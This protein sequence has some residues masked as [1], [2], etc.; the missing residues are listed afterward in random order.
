[1]FATKKLYQLLDLQAYN[2]EKAKAL[3]LLYHGVNQKIFLKKWDRLVQQFQAINAKIYIYLLHNRHNIIAQN[4][5]TK[6]TPEQ[7]LDYF[8]NFYF[9]CTTRNKTYQLNAGQQQALLV[10]IEDAI[11]T[12]ETGKNMRYKTAIDVY[13]SS[14][15]WIV[16]ELFKQRIS[17]INQLS[18]NYNRL[19][20]VAQSM[21][22]HTLLV[23][24]EEAEK[25]QLG[26]GIPAH[27]RV[28]DVYIGDGRQS[29]Q[30]YFKQHYLALLR[31]YEKEL[32][33]NLA[34]Y[35]FMQIKELFGAQDLPYNGVL[36]DND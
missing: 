21:E 28:N 13:I 31:V 35:I 23:M 32:H 3:N 5:N 26:V 6:V 30:T 29:R 25:L 24:Y 8:E 20:K 36:Q 10:L 1:M 16:S 34:H 18:S 14:G 11:D 12:C 17:I 33:F 22:I 7:Y 2:A 9:L 19:Y 27:Q 15:N 4:N